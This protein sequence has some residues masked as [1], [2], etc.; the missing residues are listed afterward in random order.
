[1]NDVT[2]IEKRLQFTFPC[3]AAEKGDEPQLNGLGGV[4]FV[5]ETENKFLFIEVKDLEN[6]G[7]PTTERVKWRQRLLYDKDNPFLIE[8]GLKFKDTILRR[9][10]R[11]LSFDKP[12]H[13]IVL[14][15]FNALDSRQKEK[16]T[17]DL[18]GQLPMT[19][20]QK[21]GFT[22]NIRIK[23]REILSIAD[24]QKKYREYTIDIVGTD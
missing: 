18:S 17:A 11:E 13:Y 14:L 10:G 1:M 22:R 21:H 15:E 24:W 6:P 4:D 19:I 16:L 8:L 12:I 2:F 5:V 23:H 20:T 9:W 7:V 3:I